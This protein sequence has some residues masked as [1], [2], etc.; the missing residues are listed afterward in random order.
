MQRVQTKRIVTFDLLRGFFILVII[1]DHLQRWPGVFDWFTG[2]GRLWV[3]AAEGF[4]LISGIMIGLIR[5]HKDKSLPLITVSKKLW[6]RAFILYIWSVITSLVALVIVLNWQTNFVPYP[7]GSDSFN[8]YSSWLSIVI[9]S[10]NLTAV[11]GWTNFLGLYAVFLAVSPLAIWLLR[12]GKWWLLLLISSLIWMVGFNEKNMFFSW[13]LLFFIGSTFGYYFRTITIWW[14]SFKYRKITSYSI[15]GL[16]LIII[17]T[18]TLV[19]FGWPIV[20][21]S[22]SPITL[23]NFINFRNQIDPYFIREELLPA[24]LFATL[25]C[26]LGLFLVVNKYQHQI[27]KLIGWLLLPFGRHSLF[28][29]ILQGIFVI[30]VAGLIP[31]LDNILLNALIIICS[32]LMLWLLTTKVKFLHKIIPS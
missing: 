16:S 18:S 7:P 20:K 10:L 14:A 1:A 15:V 5:G 31:P 27:Y 28:V 22:I 19:I 32:V 8:P 11:F 30:I 12:N 24:R 6:K 4:I 26:F 25:V 13:Q 9:Q 21:S 3:S 2:Q 23:E 29:Y 17:T